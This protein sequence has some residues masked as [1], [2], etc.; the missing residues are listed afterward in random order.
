MHLLAHPSAFVGSVGPPEPPMQAWNNTP[1]GFNLRHPVVLT[2]CTRILACAIRRPSS[3]LGRSDPVLNQSCICLLVHP[4]R[5]SHGR[6]R[7]AARYAPNVH[8]LLF[9]VCW[10]SCVTA[11]RRCAAASTR[12][13]LHA[14]DAGLR[15]DAGVCSFGL[16]QGW[17]L[18]TSF[19]GSR[20]ACAL[21]LCQMRCEM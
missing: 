14:R 10:R 1:P 16:R 7:Q 21:R 18:L 8:K 9:H 5:F 19:H 20:C 12:A 6:A 17:H 2:N 13:D 11:R 15:C 4:S 3:L